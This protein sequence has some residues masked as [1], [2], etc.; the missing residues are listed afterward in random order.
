MPWRAPTAIA[1]LCLGVLSSAESPAADPGLVLE[2]TI[3]LGKVA[4]RID[5]LAIDLARKR[6]FVSELGAN[7]VAVVDLESG[8]VIRHIDGLSEPQGIGYSPDADVLAIANAGDGSVRLFQGDDLRPTGAI[9]LGDDAD[10]I[11]TSGGGRLVV[12]YGR[13]GLATLDTA[14]RQKVADIGLPAHPEG[15]QIDPTRQRI[16]VNLPTANQIAVIDSSTG[17]IVAKWGSWLATGNF[18]MALDE[19]GQRLFSGYRGLPAVVAIDTASGKILNKVSAC[20]DT[21]DI[22]YDGLRKRLYMSCGDG[23]IAIFDAASGLSEKPM[24]STRAGART[25]LF[26]PTLDRLFVAVPLSNDLPAEI[27]VFAPQ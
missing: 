12:G 26:V 23:R 19:T 13:G 1:F 22:F 2:R 21:D 14:I 17:K 24:V 15:F 9:T 10:N 4:G 16:Y 11:R 7:A 3:D 20:G 27:R 25:S 5:H 18:P 6:L 8:K